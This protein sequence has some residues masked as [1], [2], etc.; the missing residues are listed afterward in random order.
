MG[1]KVEFN[2]DLALRRFGT[3]G[4]GAEKCLPEKLVA[5]QTYKFLKEGQRNYWMEGEVPLVATEGN[6]Q[7]S[8]PVASVHIREATHFVEDGRV[9]TRGL[10]EVVEVFD[11]SDSQVHF[12]GFQRI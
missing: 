5:G 8:R 2:P 10:Y 4:R 6:G 12:D 9:N 11:S 3:P 1:I 7:L